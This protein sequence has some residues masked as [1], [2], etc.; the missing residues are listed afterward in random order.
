MVAVWLIALLGIIVTDI[1][2]GGLGPRFMMHASELSQ[3]SNPTEQPTCQR[4]TPVP[5]SSPIT[6]SPTH[7][8]QSDELAKR[9][10]THVV[11]TVYIFFDS[12]ALPAYAARMLLR[13]ARANRVVLIAP[14]GLMADAH[15][16]VT[17]VALED[18]RDAEQVRAF[19]ASYRPWGLREPWE[20]QNTERWFVLLE[21]MR[22]TATDEALY[23]D[24]DVA[25][26]VDLSQDLPLAEGCEA[27]LD[28]R[29]GD[30][31][32][33]K[34]FW[35]VWAGTSR[36]T[37]AV[38]EDFAAFVLKMYSSP[39]HVATLS[40][41]R[42]Q[43]PYVCDMTLWYLFVA[44]SSETHARAWDWTVVLPN[45]SSHTFCSVPESVD[46]ALAHQGKRA[47]ELRGFLTLHFQ[48]GSKPD[49]IEVL[50]SL[51]EAV[52][53]V[54]VHSGFDTNLFRSTWMPHTRMRVAFVG[55]CGG[56]S[57]AAPRD[58]ERGV[59]QGQGWP[60]TR[61]MFMEAM[62]RYPSARLFMKIDSDTYV[63]AEKLERL[64]GEYSWNEPLYVG[65][66]VTEKTGSYAQG[67][68]GYAVT[69]VALDRGF[70]SFPEC[71]SMPAGLHAILARGWEDVNFGWCMRALNVTLQNREEFLEATA[72]VRIDAMHDDVE[73]L[74]DR[75]RS[76]VTRHGY[77]SRTDYVAAHVTAFA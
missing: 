24:S 76:S 8:V 68:A 11:P 46:H 3:V 9:A 64:L 62:R 4:F 29:G 57:W 10:L 14:R 26:L 31:R 47:D 5:S 73:A 22:R 58:V 75:M 1:M 67:G 25:A 21:W 28:F 56:C 50:D 36:L 7:V 71:A 52:M 27:A 74:R 37:R 42:Q 39:E 18:Y 49:A 69:R 59:G 72:Q 70:T 51:E 23:L 17:R 53:L 55:E 61:W 77:K 48:G 44:A 45:T 32:S 13:T 41:K 60:K 66:N 30:P 2:T 34:F 16:N 38:L 65:Y 54:P 19:L 6:S 15:V 63:L 40:L 33:D 35:A 20:R 43:A 12:G